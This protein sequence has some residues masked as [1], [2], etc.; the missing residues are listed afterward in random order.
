MSESHHISH[1]YPPISDFDTITA[2]KGSVGWPAI[3]SS[4]RHMG[5]FMDW[6]DAMK[7]SLKMNRKRVL[8]VL[9][10]HGQIQMMIDLDWENTVKMVSKLWQKRQPRKKQILLFLQH[11][12]YQSYRDGANTNLVSRVGLPSL[13]L[14]LIHI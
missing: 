9:V 13:C 8:T 11:I 7:A 2:Q 5:R 4:L 6:P 10:V 12:V 3:L 1:R 14:S